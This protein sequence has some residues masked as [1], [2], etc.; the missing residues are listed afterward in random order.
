MS[1]HEIG[2]DT[3]YNNGL[4]DF[5]QEQIA[6]MYQTAGVDIATGLPFD[7]S[8]STSG[9]VAFASGRLTAGVLSFD[10]PT[11][12]IIKSAKACNCPSCA[13]QLANIKSAA[14]WH[15]CAYRSEKAQA[16]R[17]IRYF[18][19]RLREIVLSPTVKHN[20]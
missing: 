8:K 17:N 18:I 10:A 14:D 7:A 20:I 19:H 16:M 4:P 11:W 5:T 9:K 2:N 6:E 12:A 15:K 3:R 13:N 1:K